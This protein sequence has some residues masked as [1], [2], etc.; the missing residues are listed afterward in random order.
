M[1]EKIRRTGGK[2][3]G[4]AQA[5]KDAKLFVRRGEV[6]AL[7][8]EN[9]AGKSTLMKCI[10]FRL[11]STTSRSHSPLL[12]LVFKV[13]RYKAVLNCLITTNEIY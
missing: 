3:F 10:A 4:G 5:L 8:G 12:Y 6:H 9:G 7:L 1:A 2:N 11:Y 13:R